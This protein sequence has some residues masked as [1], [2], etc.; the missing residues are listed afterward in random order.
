MVVVAGS[1]WTARVAGFDAAEVNEAALLATRAAAVAGLGVDFRADC[2]CF[3][4]RF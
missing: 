2:R 3:G 4:Q 1:S